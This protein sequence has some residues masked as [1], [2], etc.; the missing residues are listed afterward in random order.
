M[1]QLYTELPGSVLSRP[2]ARLTVAD[3]KVIGGCDGFCSPFCVLGRR[4]C[5]GTG[6]ERAGDRGLLLMDITQERRHHEITVHNWIIGSV[7]TAGSQ[8][9]GPDSGTNRLDAAHRNREC[10]GLHL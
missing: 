1:P 4:C 2:L 5:S 9:A 8:G 10:D 6:C 3:K 7:G